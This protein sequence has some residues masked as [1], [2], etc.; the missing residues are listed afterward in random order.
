MRLRMSRPTWSVP[1][2]YAAW[3]LSAH[4]G[5][6]KRRIKL[7]ER[8]PGAPRTGRISRPRR[9]WPAPAP[10]RS[11]PGCA[12]TCAR[13]ASALRPPRPAPRREAARPACGW[14]RSAHPDLGVEVDVQHVHCEVDEH[15]DEGEQEHPGLHDR[16]V[17]LTDRA[18]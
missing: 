15:D 14:P 10:P 9:W 3:P 17:E 12:R 11:R 8:D 1:S 4:T 18:H 13:P 5:G 2:G 6:V 16:E 7:A